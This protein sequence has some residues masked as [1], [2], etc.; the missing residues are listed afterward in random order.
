MKWEPVA[1]KLWKFQDSCVVYAVEAP[2]GMVA[3]NAGT[4]AW[5]R[6]ADQLPK[7]VTAVLCTHFFRDHAAGAAVA[8]DRGIPIYAPYWEQEQLADASGLFQRRETYIIYDNIW[9]LYAPVRD[10]PVSGLLLDWDTTTVSGLDITVVPTPGASPGAVS[11]ECTVGQ[12]RVVFC[13][14]VIHS[15]GK[16]PRIAPLQYNYND[17]PG[18]LNAVASVRTLLAREADVLAPSMGPSLITE[19]ASALREL[20]ENLRF[21]VAE[22][23]GYL[24]A[25]ATLDSD[26]VHRVTD[27][28]FQLNYAE[29]STYI[30]V[31]ESGKA[32]AI[33][34]GYR[35]HTPTGASYPFPRNRRS[36]IHVVDALRRATG[37]ESFDVVLVSHFH[38][39]HVNGIPVLQRLY[40]TRCWAGENFAPIL[41]DPMAY[42]FPCTWPEKMDVEALALRTPVRWEEYELTLYPMSGH[43]R[44]ST[45]IRF[46]VDGLVAMVTGD[47]YFFQGFG[48]PG[49]SPSMHNHVYRNGARLESFRDSND[50]LLDVQPDLILPGHGPAYRSNDQLFRRIEEYERTYRDLH[51]RLMPLGDDDIHF[52][53]DSRAAFLVPYR[54][55]VRQ[56]QTLRFRA[57]VRNPYNRDAVAHLRLVSD[58]GWEGPEAEVPLAPRGEKAADVEIVPP[59]G[60]RCRRRPVALELVADD[61][62]FGQVAEALVTIGHP[63]W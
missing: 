54:V 31:S 32:L 20:E 22:R 33:D 7:P 63:V 23:P 13:G 29:S 53:V 49:E 12:Q 30:L 18:A 60:T 58:E 8:A 61:R 62:P 19:P 2:Q 11:L 41:A 3:V 52:D 26:P 50:I 40:G 25:L 24:D 1:P 14:E 47:Q 10:I 27:H 57:T 37:I 4:G 39:D 55:H 34:C 28:L 44:W 59:D 36:S 9:D 46:E 35:R 16:I 5:V 38:D 51:I 15:P 6:C 56:A 48:D 21:A 42:S 45:L 43:T 17:L